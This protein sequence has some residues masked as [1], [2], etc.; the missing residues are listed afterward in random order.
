M[1]LTYDIYPIDI[2]FEIIC[3]WESVIDEYS[4]KLYLKYIIKK[5]HNEILT[6][7]DIC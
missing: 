2:Q 6:Y 1:L 3:Y 7:F 5:Q 4:N